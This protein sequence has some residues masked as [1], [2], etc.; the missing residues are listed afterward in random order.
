VLRSLN[1]ALLTMTVFA[2]PSLERRSR[3]AI[4]QQL[5]SPGARGKGDERGGF[6]VSFWRP[7]A[8]AIALANGDQDTC[9]VFTS[10]TLKFERF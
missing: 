7:V 5:S 10:D 6:A 9:D 2:D 3:L 4:L 8:R 1:V